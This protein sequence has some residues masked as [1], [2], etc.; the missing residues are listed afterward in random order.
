MDIMMPDIPEQPAPAPWLARRERV[1]ARKLIHDVVARNPGA[2]IDEI[3][4]ELRKRNLDVSAAVIASL[5]QRR[6]SA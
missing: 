4:G 6:K 3:A 1:D 5:M 2:T